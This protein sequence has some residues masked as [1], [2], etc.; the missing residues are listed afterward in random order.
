MENVEVGGGDEKKNKEKEKEKDE[1]RAD[2]APGGDDD[3]DSEMEIEN[4]YIV[5]TY[6]VRP[7]IASTSL[8]RTQRSIQLKLMIPVTNSEYTTLKS[9][10]L[11]LLGWGVPPE[12]L[13]DVG[14]SPRVLWWH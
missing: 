7:G 4:E 14:V 13:L 3:Y 9:T 12:Y 11:D 10:T 8:N 2:A 5:D 1:E 6:H